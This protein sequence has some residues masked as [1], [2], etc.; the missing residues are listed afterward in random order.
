MSAI[1]RHGG[2]KSTVAGG[3]HR[4][5]DGAAPLEKKGGRHISA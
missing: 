5:R 1:N 2:R 3:R 4:R